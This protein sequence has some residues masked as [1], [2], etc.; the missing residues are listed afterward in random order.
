MKVDIKTIED[1][2]VE[3]TAVVPAKDFAPYHEKAMNE[4][5]EGVEIDGFRKGKAPKDIAMK[6]INP[7]QVLERAANML[8][9]EK[10]V[11]IVTKNNIKAIGFPQVAITKIGEGSDLEFKL[12]T[13]VFPEI[14]LGDYKKIAKKINKNDIDVVVEQ[15]EVDDAV[16]NLRK[17]RA[18]QSSNES[19]DSKEPVS[20][21][22]IKE[23]DL[24]PLDD[25][26]AKTLGNFKNVDDFL[27]KVKENLEM[28][29]KGK[30]EEKQKMDIIDAI[31]DASEIEV[32]QTM[33]EYETGMMM[34]EME[35]NISMTGTS[36]DDYLKSINKTRE[37]YI[38]EWKPQATKRAQ[39][40]L[41][42]DAIAEAEK[43]EADTDQV[44]KEVA[45]LMNQYKD[46]KNI[47]ENNVRGYVTRMLTNQKVFDFLGEQK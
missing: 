13:S 23:E 31:I 47:D 42:L 41:L 5:L 40:Q 20:W 35:H 6:S 34:R 37:D 9:S 36:F 17:M 44:E 2:Q 33:I 11:D 32:P 8:I 22:D 1:S 14:K 43:I 15:S 24:P 4:A 39:T 29:K 12:T 3:I 7:M 10:Y 25:E 45:H 18:Q 38:T 16:L 46:N 27:Q 19:K 30:A 28:D 21:S 26:F